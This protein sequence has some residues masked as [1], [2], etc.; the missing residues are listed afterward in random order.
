MTAQTERSETSGEQRPLPP[1]LADL[2]AGAYAAGPAHDRRHLPPLLCLGPG[3]VASRLAAGWSEAGGA[4]HASARDPER[5]EALRT[6]GPAPG[7]ASPWQILRMWDNAAAVPPHDAVWLISAPPTPEGC[8]VH[9]WLAA[10]AKTA[11]VVIYL[12]TT[13][14]YG[15][16]QG[17]WAFEHRRPQ[18]GNARSMA[19]LVAEAEWQQ[20]APHAVVL[21]LPAIYG[22]GRTPFAEL[23]EGRARIIHKEGQVFSRIHVDDIATACALAALAGPITPTQYADCIFNIADDCPASPRV[24]QTFAAHLLGL[25]AP[26]E[27]PLEAARLS[28]M[29]RS[30][31]AECKRVP[32]A[33]AKAVL[34]WR[35]R[36]P[37]F[38]EGFAACLQEESRAQ[39]VEPG[40]A[41]STGEG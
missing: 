23:R 38:R 29:G 25:P 41:R 28:D 7:G 18:P 15:D 2:L 19:R 11:R 4:I 3:Y 39:G 1:R 24:V 32:N 13:G 34:G 16:L 14:V 20:A 17:G 27:V 10:H 9:A 6:S 26:P 40:R 22:P 35:P 5:A 12:S 30:F 21:R 31:Y 36:Y 37:S 8:P 33:R